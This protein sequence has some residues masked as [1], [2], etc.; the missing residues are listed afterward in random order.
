LN[1]RPRAT[2][3]VARSFTSKLFDQ[4]LNFLFLAKPFQLPDDARMFPTFSKQLFDTSN[5]I[6]FHPVHRNTSKTVPLRLTHGAESKFPI[7]NTAILISRDAKMFERYTQGA[8]RVIFFAR[9]E[10]MHYGS[11]YIES[12][13]LLLG[14]LHENKTLATRLAGEAGSTESFRKEIEAKTTIA[15]SLTG[16]L[17]VPLSADSKRIL[18]LAAD[19]ADALGHKQVSLGHCLL[20]ILRVEKSTAARIL[21]SHG[22]TILGLR[23]NASRDLRWADA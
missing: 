19:E 21:Q 4:A 5:R 15:Q 2:A 3:V 10:A 6:L 13:H 20:G 1:P 11:L 14:I 17:D 12:E 22:V 18:I 9:Q 16:P 8:R 7:K 23:E